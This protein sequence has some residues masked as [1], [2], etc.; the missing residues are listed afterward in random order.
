MH[1]VLITLE[2]LL[3]SART[4]VSCIVHPNVPLPSV[5][6]HDAP[7]WC[8]CLPST[9][10]AFRAQSTLVAHAEEYSVQLI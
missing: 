8:S 9:A 1:A 5:Q 6:L 2:H 3:H 10:C 4:I 7:L